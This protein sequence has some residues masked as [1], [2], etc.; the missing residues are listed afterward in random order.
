[1]YRLIAPLAGF[2]LLGPLCLWAYF[3]IRKHELSPQ[4]H[5]VPRRYTLLFAGYIFTLVGSLFAYLQLIGLIEIEP[6]EELSGPAA[7]LMPNMFLLI[8]SL[9]A[10]L[11]LSM[12]GGYVK[13][14]LSSKSPEAV[15]ASDE[16]V[17]VI[18]GGAT[19]G[20]TLIGMLVAGIVLEQWYVTALA[21]FIGIFLG[22]IGWV[23]WQK[24]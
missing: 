15:K 8:G 23:K 21:L 18:I 11:G 20:L 22:I 4:G 12:L 19:G 10:L 7:D 2:M 16:H 6:A 1:M 13:D 24:R 14:R 9:F 17:T 3:D 5:S